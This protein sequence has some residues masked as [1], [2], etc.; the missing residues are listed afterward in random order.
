MTHAMTADEPRR[1]ENFAAFWPYYVGEHRNPLCRGLHYVAGV[2]AIAVVV[3]AAW[4]T[5][6]WLLL[7]T[8]LA[9]YSVAWVGHLYSL[10]GEAKMFGLMLIGRMRGEVERIYGSA[11]PAPDAPQLAER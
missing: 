1:F 9:G 3:S 5:A 7:L 2:L 8:P 10:M 4:S 11:H 6:W